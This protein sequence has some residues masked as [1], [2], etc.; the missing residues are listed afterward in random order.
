MG[1]TLI[2]VCSCCSGLLMAAA[3]QKTRTC[4]YCGSHVNV[5]KALHVASAENAFQASEILKEIKRKKGFNR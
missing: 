3:D 1:T 4:P 2:I 5:Q